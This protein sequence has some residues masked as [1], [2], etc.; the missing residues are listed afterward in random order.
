V[1]RD[2]DPVDPVTLTLHDGGGFD[3]DVTT[4]SDGVKELEVT[5]CSSGS[6]Q[7]PRLI[8]VSRTHRLTIRPTDHLVSRVSGNMV[9]DDVNWRPHILEYRG[10][11]QH[12]RFLRF[13]LLFYKKGVFYVFSTFF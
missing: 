11:I 2:L 12:K 5:S 8:Y 3:D 10:S 6:P 4:G 13:V 9:V 1:S 7:E